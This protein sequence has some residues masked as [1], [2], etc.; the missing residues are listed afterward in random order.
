MNVKEF[1]ENNTTLIN[2]VIATG[3]VVNNVKKVITKTVDDQYFVCSFYVR[4][5]R[6]SAGQYFDDINECC[7][8]FYQC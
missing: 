5:K 2:T 8:Y 7:D 3:D 6:L 4:H 1:I